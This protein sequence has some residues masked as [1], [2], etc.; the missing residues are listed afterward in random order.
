MVVERAVGVG[1]L[2]RAGMSSVHGGRFGA[3]GGRAFGAAM[4]RMRSRS[5]DR[6]ALTR[7]QLAA[8][9]AVYIFTCLA[10]IL[11][12]RRGM[13]DPLKRLADPPLRAASGGFTTLG[14]TLQGLG[15]RLDGSRD[16]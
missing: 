14:T 8:L 1:Y 12:D 2:R 15:S 16:L 4:M 11:I 5:T 6:M 7:G 9:A 3:G 10:F 13:L